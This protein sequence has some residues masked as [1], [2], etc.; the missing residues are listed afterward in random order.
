MIIYR[1]FLDPSKTGGPGKRKDPAGTLMVHGLLIGQP[2]L[3]RG[4]F[5][6]IGHR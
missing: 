5:H 6:M 4:W 2:V 3:G 1:N